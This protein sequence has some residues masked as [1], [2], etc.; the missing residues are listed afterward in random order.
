[1]PFGFKGISVKSLIANNLKERE[2]FHKQYKFT[3]EHNNASIGD[4][5]SI[6]A[7]D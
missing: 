5:L 6:L 3:I 2:H 4:L 7:K 1:M